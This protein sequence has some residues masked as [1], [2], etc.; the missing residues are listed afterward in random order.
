MK[1]SISGYVDNITHDRQST[2]I[3]PEKV[4]LGQARYFSV[5]EN[6]GNDSSY[7]WLADFHYYEH[8]ENFVSLLNEKNF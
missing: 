2:V 5:H 8:A 6:V 7:I 3:S 1:Y 4:K